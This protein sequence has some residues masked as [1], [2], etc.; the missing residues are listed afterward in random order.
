MKLFACLLAATLCLALL[1]GC[2]GS[3]TEYEPG[4]DGRYHKIENLAKPWL[5]SRPRNKPADQELVRRA[6]SFEIDA[7]EE[8]RGDKP[9]AHFPTWRAYWHAEYQRIRKN[10][11]SPERAQEVTEC[12]HYVLQRA[13]LPTCD[14]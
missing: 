13:G 8:L 10:S 5:D 4:S 3:V 9:P 2:A 1:V 11:E 14:P 7:K 6:V 12:A